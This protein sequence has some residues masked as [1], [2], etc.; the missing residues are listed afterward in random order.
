MGK[1]RVIQTFVL[2]RVRDGSKLDNGDPANNELPL[3]GEYHIGQEYKIT[4]INA[5]GVAEAVAA[6]LAIVIP[7]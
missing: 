2:L 1:F 4:E 5:R 7:E 6:N 3:L